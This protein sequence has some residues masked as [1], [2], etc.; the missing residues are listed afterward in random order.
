MADAGAFQSITTVGKRGP[1]PIVLALTFILLAGGGFISTF[2]GTWSPLGFFNSEHSGPV[3]RFQSKAEFVA[4]PQIILTLP[5]AQMRTLV[6]AIQIETTVS[7]K[8]E[9]Q[10]LLPRL[11]DSFNSF[12]SSIDIGAFEK[13]GILEIIRDE[14]A[15][16]AVYVLGK[17]SFSDVLITEFRIQ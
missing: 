16:R 12:L 2:I 4:I 11:S 6:M 10:V 5:G 3:Q 7:K 1:K 17:E 9:V 8:Q 15:N 13:R 14:L